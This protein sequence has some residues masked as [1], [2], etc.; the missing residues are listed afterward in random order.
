MSSII[1]LFVALAP[2]AWERSVK[3][4]VITD[5]FMKKVGLEMRRLQLS[6]WKERRCLEKANKKQDDYAKCR[7]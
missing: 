6:R 5:D 7:A 1:L 4:G 3:A 2:S